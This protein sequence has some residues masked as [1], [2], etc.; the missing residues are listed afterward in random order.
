MAE[1]YFVHDSAWVEDGAKIG[2]GTRVWHFCHIMSGAEIGENCNLGQNVFIGRNVK[3]G[4]NVKIQNNVSVY[5]GVILEDDVFCGPS[6]VFT[7]VKTPRAA[8]PRHSSRDYLTTLVRRGASIG[9]NATVVCGVTIG[10]WAF[11]AAG[12]VVTKDVPPYA[13]VAGVPARI[14]GWACECGM[15][16]EFQGES[17]VCREC[18]RRYRKINETTVVREMESQEED[19]GWIETCLT[20]RE[21]AAVIPCFDLTRQNAALKEELLRIIS[22]IVDKGQFILGENVAELEKEI[23]E[24]CGVRFGIGVGNCSDALYLALLACGIGP[25]DE[26][27]TTPFT[28][29][30]TAGAIAR[31]GAK[32]VFCDIDPETYNIDP[33]KIEALITGRTRAL[34]PVHLYGQPAEMDEILAVARRHNLFV[35]EDA[36]QALGAIYKGKPVGSL[37]DVACIS[38]FPTKNLGAFGDGGM[39]VTDDAGIAERLRMLRVHGSKKKYYHEILGCNSRLDE[40]QAAVLRTKLKHLPTWTA[41]RRELAHEYGRLFHAAGLASKGLLYLP[42]EKINCRHVYNQYTIRVRNRDRLQQ[43]MKEKGIGTVV[44]YP[45]PLHLQPAFAGLGYREGDFPEAE[46]AAREVLSLPMF[47]ELTYREVERVVA[48][49]RDFFGDDSR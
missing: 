48:A 43:H 27:I 13:L 28:F 38:F 34:L 1:E 47:P 29:F 21:P 40:I 49:V 14:A 16:L 42:Q 44:Y 35:I 23:A 9:A 33:Q 6:M 5:E 20:N 8:Y 41:R 19:V 17:A 7:N 46:R 18:G 24:L 22:G 31:T 4:N 39:V 10:E 12:A 37:G 32:P 45:L 36:A 26:V 30:A 11:V 2:K 25:G 3:I 15:L